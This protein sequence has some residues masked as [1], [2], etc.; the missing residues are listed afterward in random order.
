MPAVAYI[1]RRA[2]SDSFQSCVIPSSTMGT[3]VPMPI[4]RMTCENHSLVW[5]MKSSELKD[6]PA[7]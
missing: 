6:S 2:A 5:T 4:C 3:T 1:R 7:S